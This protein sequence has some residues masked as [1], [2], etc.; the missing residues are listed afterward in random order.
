[1]FRIDIE[2]EKDI[3]VLEKKIRALIQCENPGG[4]S[5]MQTAPYKRMITSLL[6]RLNGVISFEEEIK[7][8]LGYNSMFIVM[9]SNA[10]TVEIRSKEYDSIVEECTA[11]EPSSAS[12]TN[13]YLPVERK[14][15]KYAKQRQEDSF[16]S[17]FLNKRTA[18]IIII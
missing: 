7:V 6:L 2:S 9:L 5:I 18:S 16:V 14:R 12:N 8:Y 17:N 4:C 13:P 1:M 3:I 15:R 11:D 10:K